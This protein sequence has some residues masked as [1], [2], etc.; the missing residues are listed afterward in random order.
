MIFKIPPSWLRYPMIGIIDKKNWLWYTEA[1]MWII[2]FQPHILLVKNVPWNLWYWPFPPAQEGRA[3]KISHLNYTKQILWGLDL[4]FPS[5]V[6]ARRWCQHAAATYHVLEKQEGSRTKGGDEGSPG[7]ASCR[8]MVKRQSCMW[9]GWLSGFPNRLF[10][11]CYQGR[12]MAWQC[13]LVI[14]PTKV[15]CVFSRDPLLIFAYSKL[16]E[17]LL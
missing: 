11:F 9:G 2:S 15:L 7:V 17:M 3:G 1:G 4:T 13:W 5:T 14:H 8:G 16:S 12:H 10:H 6:C